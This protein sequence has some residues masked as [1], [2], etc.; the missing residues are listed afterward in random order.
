MT[1]RPRRF[2]F[3]GD[4]RSLGPEHAPKVTRAEIT[5][6]YWVDLRSISR[7]QSMFESDKYRTLTKRPG[8]GGWDLK[9]GEM[10][11]RFIEGDGAVLTTLNG[12]EAPFL[13][14]YPD[15]HQLVR[16]LCDSVVQGVGFVVEDARTDDSNPQVTLQVGG[17][18][19]FGVPCVSNVPGQE[20]TTPS[21]GRAVVFCVPDLSEPLQYGNTASGVT[22]NKVTLQG[23]AASKKSTARRA[24]N[25]LSHV[26]HDPSRFTAA[27][28]DYPKLATCWVR[29]ALRFVHSYKL[30]FVL[31]IEFL[32]QKDII[33][34]NAP[35][36]LG[37]GGAALSTTDTAARFAEIIGVLDDKT[38]Y[39]GMTRAERTFWKE[40]SFELVGRMLPVADPESDAY[41]A[42][43]E[44]G[45]RRD[46]ANN[47]W[48]S[49]ARVGGTTGEIARTPVGKLLAESLTH[50]PYVLQSYTEANNDEARLQIGVA[51]STP[52]LQSTGMADYVLLPRGS[53]AADIK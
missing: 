8:P 3:R 29:L 50:V 4:G 31:G 39:A 52:T 22:E 40:T 34:V 51:L 25:I 47:T 20:N 45:F 17:T 32:L 15:N 28:K 49:V 43:F 30:S 9:E 35:A 14:I 6:A 11:Y 21:V 10:A 5:A 46:A 44:F 16:D 42:K 26:V 1:A 38:V 36:L 2:G 24:Q 13:T 53:I 7:L 48:D 23:R 18:R 12:I 33:R 37:P 27:M 41:N 19:S